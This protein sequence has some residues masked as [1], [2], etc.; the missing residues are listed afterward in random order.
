MQN[1]NKRNIDWLLLGV[2]AWAVLMLWVVVIMRSVS[3]YLST[4]FEVDTNQLIAIALEQNKSVAGKMNN[5]D[6]L[7]LLMRVMC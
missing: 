1:S 5:D 4:C 7:L 3:I 2:I 6:V